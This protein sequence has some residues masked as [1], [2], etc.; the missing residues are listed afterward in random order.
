MV[1]ASA[2]VGL[3]WVW[4][5]G[6]FVPV[7]LEVVGAGLPGGMSSRERRGASAVRPQ[8]DHDLVAAEIR[9]QRGRGTV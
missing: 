3:C 5:Y 1:V 9:A 4:F 7:G 6:A 8:R 2:R